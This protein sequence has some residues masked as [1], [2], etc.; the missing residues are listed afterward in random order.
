MSQSLEIKKIMIVMLTKEGERPQDEPLEYPI[1][2]I[3][4]NPPVD[5]IDFQLNEAESGT[6]RKLN[7]LYAL[8]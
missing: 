8:N 7:N 4:I 1:S 3:I 6:Y 5:L 2:D